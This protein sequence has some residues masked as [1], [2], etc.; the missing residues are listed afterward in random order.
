MTAEL[1]GLRLRLLRPAAETELC[2]AKL[3]R[4]EKLIS[5]LGGEKSRWTEAAAKLGAQYECL[6]GDMLI[7]AGARM[8]LVAHCTKPPRHYPA[9]GA[10]HAPHSVAPT[11][12]E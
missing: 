4:A 7:A 9:H 8:T 3:E 1:D 11:A 2:T 10:E 12:P 5:G 6:T